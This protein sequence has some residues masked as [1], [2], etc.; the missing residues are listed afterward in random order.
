MDTNTNKKIIDVFMTTPLQSGML[1]Y[2][3]MHPGSTIYMQQYS[4]TVTG[5]VHLRRFIH[6][7]LTAFRTFPAMCT[8]FHWE[9]LSKPLQVIHEHVRV[10]FV[11]QDLREYYAEEQKTHME[12]FA[13]QDRQTGF[14]LDKP[15]LVRLSIFLLSDD[16]FQMM[17]TMHHIITDGW[18]LG[19]L[20]SE[21]CRVYN[22]KS[23]STSVIS[24]MA[25][26][27]KHYVEHLQTKDG[28]EARMWWQKY[29]K[30]AEATPLPPSSGQTPALGA[31]A[32][33]REEIHFTV[34]ETQELDEA[35]KDLGITMN[36]LFQAAWA[37]TMA[38]KTGQSNILFA[39]C[40]A[41]RP[42]EV[43]GI[44]SVYGPLLD[45]LPMRM[46]FED[47]P[48][49]QWLNSILD[50][51]LSAMSHGHLPLNELRKFS[52]D[53]GEG[54]FLNSMTVF[55]NFSKGS[56]TELPFNITSLPGFERTS[57]P[58]TVLGY[59]EESL[60]LVIIYDAALFG[61]QDV[62]D[63]LAAMRDCMLRMVREPE[64][65]VRRLF[66][67]STHEVLSGLSILQGE[68]HD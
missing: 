42:P 20:F 65:S 37:Q 63:L 38:A 19:L 32:V 25:P 62:Q 29:L 30:G 53:D 11:C 59:P 36:I 27:M 23:Q 40:V 64:E 48:V 26:S 8:S 47:I 18:S 16:S 31:K 7:W 35:T 4:F 9:G 67:P 28:T 46:D 14:T 5:D 33:L 15:P 51:T 34:K 57:Y 39:S 12:E 10:P 52:N 44:E 49:R 45:I 24:R 56:G 43:N 22:A 60:Q 55:E 50:T 21:F 58:L 54:A 66:V 2:D 6:A 41:S 3:L 17:L 1:Y 61:E 68:L 13:E